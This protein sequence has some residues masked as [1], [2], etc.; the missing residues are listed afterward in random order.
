MQTDSR[1]VRSERSDSKRDRS[2]PRNPREKALATSESSVVNPP[3]LPRVPSLRPSLARSVSRFCARLHCLALLTHIRVRVC[4][5]AC[6]SPLRACVALC[7]CALQ[8]ICACVS[9]FCA[10]VRGNSAADH[11]QRAKV[12]RRLGGETKSPGGTSSDCVAMTRAGPNP[13]RPQ[14]MM[15]EMEAKQG[16]TRGEGAACGQG[17]GC[18]LPQR[19]TRIIRLREGVIGREDG[20]VRGNGMRLIADERARGATFLTPGLHTHTHT[21]THTIQHTH[22][23]VYIFNMYAPVRVCVCVCVCVCVVYLSLVHLVLACACRM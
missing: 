14:A 6:V 16:A 8:C 20:G 12:T 3:L 1:D 10:C 19:G 7:L 4:M 13:P 5:C 21:H 11:Q 15:T 17:E 23:H 2:P 9:L 22:T 18:S